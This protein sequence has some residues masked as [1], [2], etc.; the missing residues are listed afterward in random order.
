MGTETAQRVMSGGELGIQRLS[1]AEVHVQRTPQGDGG[2]IYIDLEELDEEELENIEEIDPEELVELSGQEEEETSAESQEET[3]EDS[4]GLGEKLKSIGKAAV[5]GAAGSLASMGGKELGK[6]GGGTIGG[7]L[8]S[9]LGPLGAIAGTKIG[10]NVGEAVGSGVASDVSKEV[11]GWGFSDSHA[12]TVD[13]LKQGY[14]ELKSRVDRIEN[15]A[16]DFGGEQKF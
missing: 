3:D 12:E 1:K 9:L 7:L 15:E 2:T 11:T 5:K 4:G 14:A 16:F 6:V 13:E 8:G 10:E